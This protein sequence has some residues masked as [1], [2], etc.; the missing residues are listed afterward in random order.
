MS[1]E[2]GIKT[3]FVI[4]PFSKTKGSR[5]E[6]YWDRHWNFLKEKIE[7]IPGIV[8]KRSEA[9][10]GDILRQIIID[11]YSADIVVAD[12]TDLN[13]NVYW[14][15]G[16]RQSYKNGTVTIAESKRRIAFDMGM[17]SILRYYPKDA[18][19]NEEFVK[20]FKKA[21]IDCIDNP[22]AIDSHVLDTLGGR[23]SLYQI[24]N[25]EENLR[26]IEALLSEINYNRTTFLSYLT[27]SIKNLK[28]RE[29]GKE[30]EVQM[31]S[32]RMVTS[33]IELLLVNRYLNEPNE[34]YVKL[35]I[36]LGRLTGIIGVRDNWNLFREPHDEWFVKNEKWANEL[37]DEFKKHIEEV[38]L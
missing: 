24:I 35:Q 26:R 20:Q 21:I 6:E 27:E 13:P 37:F 36:Y 22:D 25:H 12:L 15:L 34:F 28:L 14:E 18:M 29:A 8:A 11:L 9:L 30:D 3:C 1:N 38:K 19:K 33:A 32:K 4:M 17:K 23:G 2:E 31:I 10:R 5:T 16:V 7:E